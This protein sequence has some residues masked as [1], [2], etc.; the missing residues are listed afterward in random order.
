MLNRTVIGAIALCT[1]GLLL[2]GCGGGS[3]GSMSPGTS[4]PVVQPSQGQAIDT[5]QLLAMAQVT[6]ETTDPKPVGHGALLVADADDQTSEP[7]PVG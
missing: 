1:A 7:I 5:Q 3:S 2:F 6:S 4:M